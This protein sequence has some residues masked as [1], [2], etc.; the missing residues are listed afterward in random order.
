MMVKKTIGKTLSTPL[1]FDFQLFLKFH[2]TQITQT[3][4][5]SDAIIVFLNTQLII[6]AEDCKFKPVLLKKLWF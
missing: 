2:W 1:L 4:M 5:S 6:Y 3:R